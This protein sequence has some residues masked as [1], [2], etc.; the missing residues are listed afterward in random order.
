MS[1]ATLRALERRFLQTGSPMD[2]ARLLR[3]RVLAGDLDERD[4]RFA[5]RLG[6][7]GALMAVPNVQ[8]I[9]VRLGDIEPLL[10][11]FARASRNAVKALLLELV[12][13]FEWVPPP[14][15]AQIRAVARQ[16]HAQDRR[17]APELQRRYRAVI[18]DRAQP[19]TKNAASSATKLST[20][21]VIR[22]GPASRWATH[23]D[24]PDAT[25]AGHGPQD[26]M[27]L[28]SDD[29]RGR[30]RAETRPG[31]VGKPA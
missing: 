24:A 28:A 22:P 20:V 30:L 21:N 14:R 13:F 5:A 2:E 9:Q 12:D 3:A 7:V 27:C 18:S 8:P 19:A 25:C 10:R 11:D 17:Q 29:L 6:Q 16:V 31:P 26:P 23:R 15:S 1:D 4:L